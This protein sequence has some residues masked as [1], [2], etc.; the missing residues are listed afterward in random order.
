M[1][2][3]IPS[4]ERLSLRGWGLCG[5]MIWVLVGCAADH[6][7]SAPPTR[8]EIRTDAERFFDK[9]QGEEAERNTQSDG[10]DRR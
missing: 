2:M 10:G 6:P 9:L 1:S 8:Q 3:R 7:T 4:R 5:C